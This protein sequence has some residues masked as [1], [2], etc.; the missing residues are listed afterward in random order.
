MTLDWVSKLTGRALIAVSAVAA[1]S[2]VVLREIRFEPS[3]VSFVDDVLIEHAEGDLDHAERQH[4]EKRQHQR[5]L[6]DRLPSAV[7]KTLKRKN[8]G[9]WNRSSFFIADSACRTIC[10]LGR[11]NGASMS[12]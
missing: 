5:H 2:S 9:H 11:K 1:S 10:P 8:G 6:D 3:R 12:T 4:H 7:A